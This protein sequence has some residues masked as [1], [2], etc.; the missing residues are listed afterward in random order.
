MDLLFSQ[1][2]VRFF[3]VYPPNR[4]RAE[5]MSIVYTI[6]YEGTDIQTFV[7]TLKVV[8]VKCLADVR[9]VA[10]SRKKG[11]S[12]KALS[13]RL[14]AEGIQYVH[15]VG[16]GDPKPGREAARAGYYQKFR[17]IYEAH[18]GSDDAQTS[19]RQLM[20]LA[21][22]KPTCLLCFERDPETCHRSIVAGEM[23]ETG[24]EVFDLLGDD[25]NRYVHNAPRV[26]RR[27]P[28]QGVAAA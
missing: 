7:S 16:L 23:S 19:L 4:K 14:E 9:A 6:G 20:K 5:S 12:K 8:G 22:S 13:A 11:F 21:E 24:F 10:L 27:Y 25:P 1:G 17:D 18:L 2:D 15:F 26:P 3:R 28:R